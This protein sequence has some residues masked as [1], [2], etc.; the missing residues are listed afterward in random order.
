MC[1]FLN[2][3]NLYSTDNIS[4]SNLKLLNNTREA[5]DMLYRSNFSKQELYNIFSNLDIDEEII[6]EVIFEIQNALETYI[7]DK[8]FGN[9]ALLCNLN[10]LLNKQAYIDLSEEEYRQLILSTNTVPLTEI[11]PKEYV[12]STD[13]YDFYKFQSL[14]E[15]D[16]GRSVI[17]S[18]LVFMALSGVAH[19]AVEVFGLLYQHNWDPFQITTA[20]YIKTREHE[21][22]NYFS[23]RSTNASAESF[24]AKLKGFRSLV[25]GVRDKA[26]FLYRVSKIYG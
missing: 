6:N 14:S 11:L 17:G 5:V 12:G 3:E 24:N 8:N 23:N 1:S 26:F 19:S 10:L 15:D 2:S 21:I 7:T 13:K 18:I 22:L 16:E 9:T 25:R 20:E 4:E